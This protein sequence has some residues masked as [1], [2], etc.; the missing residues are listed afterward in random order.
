VQ[1]IYDFLG[2]EVINAYCEVLENAE[3]CDVAPLLSEIY[4]EFYLTVINNIEEAYE[5]TFGEGSKIDE[6]LLADLGIDL[7]GIP[8]I[9]VVCKILNIF[10]L[11]YIF[12]STLYNFAPQNLLKEERVYE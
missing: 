6:L 12:N 2:T 3:H 8:N 5:S 1:D 4:D 9:L 11:G 10:K 7:H